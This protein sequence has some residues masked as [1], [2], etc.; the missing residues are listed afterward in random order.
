MLRKTI[1]AVATAGV[2]T[3]F[4]MAQTATQPPSQGAQQF[5]T[6]AAQGGMF[7][8]QSSQ[9]AQTKAQNA[10]VK[11]FARDMIR[12]HS[13][14]N[15]DLKTLTTKVGVRVPEQLDAEHA[16]KLRRLQAASGAEFDRTYVEQQV[17]AHE[18]SVTLFRDYS[19]SGD[20]AELR[21][22]AT[23][24]LPVL[25]QHKT[26]IDRLERELGSAAV[27]GSR[28]ESGSK[29]GDDKRGSDRPR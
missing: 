16:E 18:Q 12:D 28:G 1:A 14:A 10:E 2:L 6:K 3:T 15:A 9:V 4:L 24:T 20:N 22:F 29:K 13:K 11:S 5:V 23:R 19:Q 27:G 8:V 25:Q 17:Q 26:Q 7:E 21:S